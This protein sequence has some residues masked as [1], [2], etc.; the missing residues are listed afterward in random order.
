MT[1][2][3]WPSTRRRVQPYRSAPLGIRG[4]TA[5]DLQPGDGGRFGEIVYAA[6]F[7]GWL[8]ALL[9]WLLASTTSTLAQIVLIWLIGDALWSA[10]LWGF[11][12]PP[13]LERDLWCPPRGLTQLRTGAG[14]PLSRA[15]VTSLTASPLT[16]VY[17]RRFGGE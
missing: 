3:R 1:A 8:M 14:G 17:N 12:T 9:A 7:A 16:P 5:S 6:V 13:V 2:A 15:R 4:G 11:V 10:M